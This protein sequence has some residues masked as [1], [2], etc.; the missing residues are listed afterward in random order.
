[1]L[2]PS[3][4][5]LT[6]AQGAGQEKEPGRLRVSSTL[7]IP[8]YNTDRKNPVPPGP[9]Y[10]NFLSGSNFWNVGCW[11]GAIAR[12]VN[13]GVEEWVCRALAA[14]DSGRDGGTGRGEGEDV[15]EGEGKGKGKGEGELSKLGESGSNGIGCTGIVVMDHVGESGDWD[16]VDLVIGFNGFVVAA[17]GK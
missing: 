15:V 12:V 2:P 4:S 7:H 10:L 6:H 13:R 14:T 3:S 16:L 11:P 9:I 8:G 5:A 1:L 17:M